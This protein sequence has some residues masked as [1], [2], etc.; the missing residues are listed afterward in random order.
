MRLLWAYA[1]D[2]RQTQS[3][4]KCAAGYEANA[5]ER[6]SQYFSGGTRR[7][8]LWRRGAIRP[9]T[10]A[11]NPVLRE[12]LSPSNGD[13]PPVTR[14]AKVGEGCQRIGLRLDPDHQNLIED[15]LAIAELWHLERFIVTLCPWCAPLRSRGSR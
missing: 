12:Q 3:Q 10:E 4:F 9:P 1:K 13:P 14:S 11:G 2:N 5:D 6:R 15:Q 8:S 7:F